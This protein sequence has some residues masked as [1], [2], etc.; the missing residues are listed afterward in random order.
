MEK[1][2]SQ[3]ARNRTSFRKIAPKWPAQGAALAKPVEIIDKIFQPVI[4]I[5]RRQHGLEIA[6]GHR[7]QA[8]PVFRALVNNTNYAFWSQFS[9]AMRGRGR[10][11]RRQQPAQ[12]AVNH[13]F[14]MPR[15]LQKLGRD[16]RKSGGAEPP[17]RVNVNCAGG[18]NPLALETGHAIIRVGDESLAVLIQPDGVQRANR[19]RTVRS[20]RIF[21]GQCS[22]SSPPPLLF[23]GRYII[24][25]DIVP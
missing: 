12:I 6:A 10:P 20:Q 24:G 23:N 17:S 22:L 16:I 21:S 25:N 13:L 1:I 8:A 19:K 9:K 5:V 2:R 18:T 11:N 14:F 3:S 4:N 7:H 15:H